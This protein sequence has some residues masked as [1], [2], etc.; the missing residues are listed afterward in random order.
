MLVQGVCREREGGG[1]GGN[2][3][4]T[5]LALGVGKHFHAE[6]LAHSCISPASPVSP[7]SP[8]LSRSHTR[9]IA[10]TTPLPPSLSLSSF[11][12][13]WTNASGIPVVM[14]CI[15][16]SAA[17]CVWQG[18]AARRLPPFFPFDASWHIWLEQAGASWEQNSCL[19]SA[20][21]RLATPP[22]THHFSAVPC[23]A[24]SL[25]AYSA[26]KI[27]KLYIQTFRRTH[28]MSYMQTHSADKCGLF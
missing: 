4:I 22:H 15:F 24:P 18:E 25:L 8:A 1:W 26:G 9:H 17:V 19:V 6:H 16:L 3:L 28:S 20:L 21:L 27:G 5:G 11:P 23:S 2:G 7:T 13:K 10:F 12:C 14:S